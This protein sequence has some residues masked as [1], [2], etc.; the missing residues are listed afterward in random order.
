VQHG[1]LTII[2]GAHAIGNIPL[3]IETLGVDAY[4]TNLHKWL[5]TPRGAALVWVS[6]L[7]QPLVRPLVTSHGVGLGFQAEHLWAGT[8]DMSV[9]L[10]AQ[11]AVE[12]FQRFGDDAMRKHRQVI[13]KSGITNMVQ[14]F[15]CVPLPDLC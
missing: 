4:V 14:A 11:T 9:W 12:V 3:A 13:L 7:L 8:A 6:K 2:D 10:S 5:C 15:Q 1:A